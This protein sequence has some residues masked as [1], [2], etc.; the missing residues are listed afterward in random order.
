MKILIE[1]TYIMTNFEYIILIS[2]C[3]QYTRGIQ[4]TNI[5]PTMKPFNRT[6]CKIFYETSFKDLPKEYT[7]NLVYTGSLDP[8]S[9]K[10]EDNLVNYPS[11]LPIKKDQLKVVIHYAGTTTASQLFNYDPANLR[12]SIMDHGCLSI[13]GTLRGEVEMK[14]K[15]KFFDICFKKIEIVNKTND[16]ITLRT[17]FFKTDTK[18]R[19]AKVKIEKTDLKYCKTDNI[20]VLGGGGSKSWIYYTSGGIFLSIIIFLTLIALAVYWRNK[21]RRMKAE[22]EMKNMLYGTEYYDGSEITEKNPSY[23]VTT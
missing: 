1:R 16:D 5:K 17:T 21:A 9:L 7:A 11:C 19:I 13:E 10:I 15:N 20:G 18:E 3:V 8:M 12:K 14:K 2:L 22:I 6:H 4:M 23:G